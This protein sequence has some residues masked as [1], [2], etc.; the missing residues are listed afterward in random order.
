MPTSRPTTDNLEPCADLQARVLGAAAQSFAEDGY[1]RIRVTN[2]AAVAGVSRASLYDHYL[3]EGRRAP[4]A[5]RVPERAE[6]PTFTEGGEQK[7]PLVF[8]LEKDPGETKPLDLAASEFEPVEKLV[9]DYL[10][11]KRIENGD[12]IERGED[13]FKKEADPALIERLRSLG[14]ME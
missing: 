14:Y 12:G 5:E 6:F 1:E 8:D 3:H 7:P 13:Q 4:C 9:D 2:V 10:W 11:R